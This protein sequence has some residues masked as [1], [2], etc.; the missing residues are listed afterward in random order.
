MQT[1]TGTGC[2]EAR[3]CIPTFVGEAGSRKEK[4]SA[5][6]ENKIQVRGVA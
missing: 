1:L 2:I 6:K 4:G 3:H 5:G